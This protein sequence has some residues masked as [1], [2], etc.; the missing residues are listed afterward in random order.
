MT[1]SI[2]RRETFAIVGESV[3]GKSTVARM[4]VGLIAPT[5]GDVVI[6]G[7]SMT[8]P[9]QARVGGLVAPP[10]VYGYKSQPRIGG[11]NHFPG[12]TSLD[13]ETVIHL[14]RDLIREFARHG[15]RKL[16]MMDAHYE[17]TMFLIEGIDLALRD[18]RAQ[19]VADVAYFEFTSEA[20]IKR[21]WPDGFSGWALEHAGI[22][23]TSAMPYLNPDRVR[24]E[25]LAEHQPASFP[26]YDVYPVTRENVPGV[27]VDKRRDA[28]ERRTLSRNGCAGLRRP[29]GTSSRSPPTPGGRPP[30]LLAEGRTMKERKRG[31]FRG[32]RN[33]KRFAALS[34]TQ[35]HE[36][37]RRTL[38]LG[39]EA[40]PSINDRTISLFSRGHQPA[41]A[42]INTFMK[43]PYC[44][45]VRKVKVYDAA[46][47]GVPFDTGTMP[48]R[49]PGGAPGL[50]PLRRLLGRRRGRPVRAVQVLRCG[51]CVRDSR[52]HR[53]E[54]RPG[55]ASDLAHLHIG[56]L[57]RHLRWRSQPRIPQRARDRSPHRRLRRHH[58]HRPAS[59]HPGKGHG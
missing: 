56:R 36:E 19:G 48:L 59:R 33:L 14:A 8:D 50:R 29:W 20:T 28:G 31:E 44:E 43:A 45:D 37:I 51:R 57:P 27:D 41:F 46:F 16:V 53:E 13:G 22:M 15:V 26:P 25:R 21:V 18:L 55:D 49:S 47:V 24:M 2:D 32:T 12:T 17:N 10:I 34:Q 39:L 52:E 40:A 30:R 5:T 3:S 54:L 1:F 23:E 42:G 7:I 35:Q 4:M 58:P 6:D 38:K 9:R 11:G